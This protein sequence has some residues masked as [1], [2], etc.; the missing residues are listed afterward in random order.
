MGA[1]ADTTTATATT[2]ATCTCNF[3]LSGLLFF[4]YLLLHLG[5]STTSPL[6]F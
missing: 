6:G 1:A 5:P 3:C 2:T 4:G